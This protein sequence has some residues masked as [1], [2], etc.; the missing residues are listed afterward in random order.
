MAGVLS[1]RFIPLY[2]PVSLTQVA[3]FMIGPQGPIMYPS[4]L[5]SVS[6]IRRYA[7]SPKIF[8]YFTVWENNFL[9]KFLGWKPALCL[10]FLAVFQIDVLLSTK[11]MPILERFMK[12]SL[13]LLP[14]SI[15]DLTVQD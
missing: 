12:I 3:A 7:K 4:T 15:S 5:H 8:F 10:S 13:A 1:K 9:N 14:S 2:C 11:K 6:K